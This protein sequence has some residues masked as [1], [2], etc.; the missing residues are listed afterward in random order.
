MC[1]SPLTGSRDVTLLK[2][3][4]TEQLIHDW[5]H[6]RLHT[7]I[8]NELHGHKEICLYQCNQ[9]KLKF[10]YP[11]D[12]AG[13][14]KLYEKL[15]NIA[16]YYMTDKWEHRVALKD[17]V[18]CEKILEIGSASGAFVQACI[19]RGLNIRGIEINDAAV[20]M[21]RQ[22][23]LPVEHLSLKQAAKLY[24][25]SF[26]A[27]CGFQVLEHVPNPRDF[28]DW[29]IKMLKQGGKLIYCVPNTESFLKYQYN[30]LDMPPHHMLQFSRETFVALQ[31]LFPLKLEKVRYEPLA[32]YHVAGY[33][34]SYGHHFCSHCAPAKILF[35]RYTNPFYRLCLSLGLRRL[36]VGQSLYVQFRRL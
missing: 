35:N 27:V 2:V 29:S 32:S 6:G 11:T 22:K 21:A 30:L 9:T 34:K 1:V 28:I 17:L 14:D 24:F 4:P 5:Q 18:G 19:D 20:R 36:L 31:E 3:I 16:S 23:G 13:S 26:D 25:E 8:T 7:D 33:M 12:I 15:Q 10:F